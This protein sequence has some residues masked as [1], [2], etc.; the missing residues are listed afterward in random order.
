MLKTIFNN[1]LIEIIT[2]DGTKNF[3]K[4]VNNVSLLPQN[5]YTEFNNMFF[6]Q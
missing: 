4:I 1:I 5:I 6:D 2:F 3:K